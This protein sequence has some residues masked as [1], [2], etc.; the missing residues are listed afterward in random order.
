MRRRS[1][2]ESS[3]RDYPSLLRDILRGLLAQ[4]PKNWESARRDLVALIKEEL[5]Q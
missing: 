4:D 2:G 3:S 5:P 1:A